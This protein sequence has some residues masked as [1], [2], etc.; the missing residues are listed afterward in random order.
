MLFIK[1]FVLYHVVSTIECFVLIMISLLNRLLN[2][3]SE[4]EQENEF[5]VLG[6]SK[7]LFV[8]FVLFYQ[9][10]NIYNPKSERFAST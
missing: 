5:D 1:S 8:M 6:L 4:R 10:G 2:F 7:S 9:K 3:K